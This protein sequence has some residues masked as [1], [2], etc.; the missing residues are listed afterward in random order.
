MSKSSILSCRWGTSSGLGE[1]VTQLLSQDLLDLLEMP[2]T[3]LEQRASVQ[4][5]L[6]LLLQLRQDP[7]ERALLRLRSAQVGDVHHRPPDLVPCE[8]GRG[9]LC[10]AGYAI[11]FVDLFRR[12]SCSRSLKRRARARP[13]AVS[14]ASRS[15]ARFRSRICSA[16]FLSPRRTVASS[17]PSRRAISRFECRRAFNAT[18]TSGSNDAG[19]LT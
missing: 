3:Q 6:E 16:C 2:W 1:D 4:R 17:T 7:V 14:S 12:F 11:S 13:L 19:L 10:V 18:K 8:I 5:V 15:R 9:L